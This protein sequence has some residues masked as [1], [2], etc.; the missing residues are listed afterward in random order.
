MHYMGPEETSAF[1]WFAQ[2]CRDAFAVLQRRL[3]YSRPL[4]APL[5]AG[6]RVEFERRGTVVA[7]TYWLGLP[8][9][10]EIVRQAA[11]PRSRFEFPYLPPRTLPRAVASLHARLRLSPPS[12]EQADEALTGKLVTAR[13][14]PGLARALR[15]HL[16]T[17][18]ADLLRRHRG[19]LA[20]ELAVA[21]DRS[22]GV[23]AER[24]GP[25][26]T[27]VPPRRPRS[28]PALHLRSA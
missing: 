28:S 7:V 3:G 4:V 15:L 21:R 6:C 12:F 22:R 14:R 17:V 26:R 23:S 24:A 1:S 18:A 20:P 5:R 10:V 8:P 25:R 13:E 11:D 27:S 16:R 2:P 9:V 19:K